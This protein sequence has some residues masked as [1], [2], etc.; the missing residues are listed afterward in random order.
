MLSYNNILF[1]FIFNIYIYV[2]KMNIIYFIEM[3]NILFSHEW[4]R[5]QLS[6]ERNVSIWRIFHKLYR[7]GFVVDYDHLHRR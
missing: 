1:Y 7:S 4:L 5:T 6:R 3:E 2:F